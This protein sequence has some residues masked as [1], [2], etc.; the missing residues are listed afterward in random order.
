MLKPGRFQKTPDRNLADLDD[1]LY[2]L[3]EDL[4]RLISGD[5]AYLKKIAGALR[6]LVCL[7]SGTE[8]LLWRVVEQ[9]EADDRL[10]LQATKGVDHANPIS[11]G[12]SFVLIPVFR[13]GEGP[14]ALEEQHISLKEFI[15]EYE[16]LYYNGKSYTHEKLISSI[17]QQMGLSHESED[18]DP[19]LIDLSGMAISDRPVLV[20]FLLTDALF[21]LEVG[22]RVLATANSKNGFQ[23]RCRPSITLP[24]RTVEPFRFIEDEHFLGR[25]SPPSKEGTQLLAIPA[26]RHGWETD[27]HSYNLGTI[28]TAKLTVNI[29]KLNDGALE[30]I[31]Y[32]LTPGILIKRSPIVSRGKP[33]IVIFL[34]WSEDGSRIVTDSDIKKRDS[35]TFCQ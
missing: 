21:T 30:V 1:H 33:E 16:A 6:T 3:K 22:E 26:P 15:K 32:G 20:E 11:Q 17:A 7:S 18:V 25:S 31:V 13:A 8:G 19:H 35:T 14:A 4:A 10:N 34:I 5:T 9:T 24:P 29:A 12:L 27:G 23:R 2:F 28:T